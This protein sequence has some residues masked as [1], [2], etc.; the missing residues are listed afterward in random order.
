MSQAHGKAS[1]YQGKRLAWN[2]GDV[3]WGGQRYRFCAGTESDIC[4]QFQGET[5]YALFVDEAVLIHEETWLE[6]MNRLSYDESRVWATCN[7]GGTR[8]FL[9]RT[10]S[11]R[12]RSPYT[13]SFIWTITHGSLS[14]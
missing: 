2:N 8:H 1:N 6:A 5:V 9:K 3:E 11:T 7:P 4:D 12:A 10:G 14:L 13:T